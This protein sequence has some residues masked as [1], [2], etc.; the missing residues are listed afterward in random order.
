MDDKLD[1]PRRQQVFPP[2]D[3]E[4]ELDR[5]AGRMKAASGVGLQ[6]LN[7]VGTQAEGML[8]M[9]PRPVRAGLERATAAALEQSF[10]AAAAT[11]GGRIADTSDWLTRAITLGTGAAGGFGGL[12]SA[13][14]ELP[15]TT[16]VILRAI[17]TI[18]DEHGFDP[19]L[20]EVRAA[21]LRVFAAAGP[22]DDDD[23][24]DLS[25]MTMRLSVTGP[26]IH[27]LI[28][29]VAPRLAV[30]LGQKLA[31]QTVPVIGAAA[32]AATNWIFTSY[33]QEVA[34]VQ[35]GLMRLGAQTGEDMNVLTAELKSR[36]AR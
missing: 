15:V 30:P 16:T 1:P 29:K 32:G 5:L 25:F 4:A 34:R 14:A 6:L 3:R 9:L 20:P 23:G 36:I 21:C 10:N 13:L 18:A 24:T 28:A 26:A 33:Y 35:F 8:D 7:L 31:A 17:Q 2:L 22:L 19:A 11:R 12:P 27:G